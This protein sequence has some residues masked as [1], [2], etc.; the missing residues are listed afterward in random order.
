M[1]DTVQEL[2]VKIKFIFQM[3][4]TNK[5]YCRGTGDVTDEEKLISFLM[6]LEA[7][8]SERCP[9]LIIAEVDIEGNRV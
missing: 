2:K 1:M 4:K 7:L 8:E 5:L 3:K 6:V 9:E